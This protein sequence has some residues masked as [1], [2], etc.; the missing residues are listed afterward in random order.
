MKKK[1]NKEL[2]DFNEVIDIITKDIKEFENN[3]NEQINNIHSYIS[4]YLYLVN[5]NNQ[6]EES[7]KND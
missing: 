6:R 7:D 1:S 2:E 3:M 4:D 5:Y